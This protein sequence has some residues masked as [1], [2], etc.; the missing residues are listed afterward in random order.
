MHYGNWIRVFVKYN[1]VKFTISL[2]WGGLV[3]TF[4]T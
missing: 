3:L 1:Y 4:A 2:K